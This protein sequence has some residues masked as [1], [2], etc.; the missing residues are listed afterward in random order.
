MDTLAEMILERD[1]ERGGG[2]VVTM[3]TTSDAG[4]A[5]NRPAPPGKPGFM[6]SATLLLLNVVMTTLSSS[7]SPQS[8][9]EPVAEALWTNPPRFLAGLASD[10]NP[11]FQ[12]A[13]YLVKGQ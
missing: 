1:K 11:G 7:R 4:A 9:G 3:P 2:I 5:Q 8:V 13:H 10:I 6:P 12:C